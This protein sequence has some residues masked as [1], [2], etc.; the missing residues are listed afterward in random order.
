MVL[1]PR[2]NPSNF[3]KPTQVSG[4]VNWKT[5]LKGRIR[6]TIEFQYAYYFLNAGHSNKK[7][8]SL[9]SASFKDSC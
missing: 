8:Q 5:G 1:N 9:R 6:S 2:A 3:K 4:I 7:R